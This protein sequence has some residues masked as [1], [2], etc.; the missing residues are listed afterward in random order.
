MSKEKKIIKLNDKELEKVNGGFEIGQPVTV[1]PYS[2]EAGECFGDEMLYYKVRN[3]Y[4]NV[5]GDTSISVIQYNLL[6][7]TQI[8]CYQKAS[9]LASRSYLGK[10]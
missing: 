4:T 8:Y 1:I 2:F 6:E 5:S 9:I 3:T 7:N 10:K